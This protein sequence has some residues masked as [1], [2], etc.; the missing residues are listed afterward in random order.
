MT[1]LH[2][3]L[4]SL[5][6]VGL[7]ALGGQA[8]ASDTRSLTDLIRAGEHDRALALVKSGADVKAALPDG[9]TPLLW[10]VYSDDADLVKAL[11]AKGARAEVRTRYGLTPLAEAATVGDAGITRQLLKAGAKPDTANDD[12]QTPLMLAART[13]VVGVAQELVEHG[14][15]VNARERWRGQTPLMWAA[16]EGH[17]EM[18]AYLL[19]RHAQPDI[20]ALV[21]DWGAQV[22]SEPRAQYRPSA[23]LTALLYAARSGCRGCVEALLKAGAD[24]NRPTPDGV[25][26]LM[27]AIDNFH[28]DLARFLLDRGADG[29]V[30]DWWG[31]TALYVAIDMNSFAPRGAGN[32]DKTT[33]LDV[34]RALLAAGVNPNSQLNMHRPGRGANSGRFTDD[35]LTVGATPLLRAAISCDNEAITL[36][37]ANGALVVLP[38]A[39][40]DTPLLAASGLGLSSRDLRG[41]LSGDVQAKSIATVGLLIKAGAD[42]NARVSDTTGRTARIA[43][44]SSMT[45]REGQTAL[46]G[47]I[48]WGWAKVVAYL[49][50]QG[51]RTDIADRAGKTPLDAVAGNAGGRDHKNAEDVAALIRGKSAPGT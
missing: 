34:A 20:R 50:E 22:T 30:S 46:Y 18:T 2:L 24:I 49:L 41:N 26:P 3:K 42:V 16:A 6:L 1:A 7:L 9:S 14:A 11:L 35:L 12:G 33:A 10:A 23:G 21:N 17:A 45:S 8:L 39:M 15:K 27:T 29:A 28:F 25:T 51:A 19:S 13:G 43:R 37:L 44:P 48:N 5:A 36:L 4:R 32:A 47:A 38:N 40:G 31:R